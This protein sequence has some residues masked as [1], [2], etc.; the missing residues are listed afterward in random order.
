MP[1]GTLESLAD[2]IAILERALSSQK[3][4]K[5]QFQNHGR[6]VNY[7]HRLYSA[8]TKDRDENRKL[9][10]ADEALYGRSAY[11]TLVIKVTDNHFLSITKADPD[12]I[13]GLV[14]IQEL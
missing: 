6:A 3:G 14:A 5:L 13:E 8:R 1:T 11:D 4:L 2:A 9:Y 10:S 12:S 7:R